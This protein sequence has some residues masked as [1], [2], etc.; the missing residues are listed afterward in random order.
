MKDREG[1]LLNAAENKENSATAALLCLVYIRSH[2][3]GSLSSAS[4]AV[5]ALTTVLV[6]YTIVLFWLTWVI[7]P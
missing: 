5:L 6:E 3:Y 1:R 7:V 4:D 2:G